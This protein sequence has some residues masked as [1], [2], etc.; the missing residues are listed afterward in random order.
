[1]AVLTR[2]PKPYRQR[3]ASRTRFRFVIPQPVLPYIVIPV[4]LTFWGL[5]NGLIEGWR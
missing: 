1:M 3:T 5:L 2:L 4:M